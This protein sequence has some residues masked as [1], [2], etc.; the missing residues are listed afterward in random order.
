MST[1]KVGNSWECRYYVRNP[2]GSLKYT[3][4]KGFTTRREAEAWEQSHK[5]NYDRSTNRFC[6]LFEMMSKSNR[7]NS[8]T[9]ETR[10]TRM[11]NYFKYWEH[12]ISSITKEMLIDWRSELETVDLATRTKN[13]LINYIKQVGRFAYNTYDIPDNTK[14][15]KTF[16]LELEDYKEM[17]ILTPDQFQ[18]LVDAET[19]E[20][21]K[22][23]WTV[24]YKTGMRKGE[25]R[26]LYR[27]DFD[28][29]ALHIYKSMRRYESS[30]KTTKNRQARV[31][32][33]DQK[34][35]ALLNT[36]HGNGKYLFGD[37]TPISLTKMED[38][39]KA[40][41]KKADLP[42]CR[43]HDLRHSHVSLLW[44]AGVPVPEISKRCGHSSPKTT[45][46]KYAH[47]FDNDQSKTLDVLNNL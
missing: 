39:F 1:K 43:I 46:E 20:V 40:A 2:D 37:Y 13:D 34:T 6:D 22:I 7:A 35:I 11:R 32:P 24:L 29:K 17:I 14:I 42:Q 45:M 38:H 9:T 8:V 5:H 33:L 28:G 4:K 41:L 15:L 12:S 21:L 3:K 16:P 30:L 31:V 26:A 27:E 44:H 36:L 18:K 23:V 19:D 47:I 10:R 25:L